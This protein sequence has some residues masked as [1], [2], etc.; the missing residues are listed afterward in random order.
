MEGFQA[1]S[2]SYSPDDH[3]ACR[4]LCMIYGLKTS[5]SR[6]WIGSLEISYLINNLFPGAEC[7]ILHSSKGHDINV[8]PH[9]HPA[10]AC[11]CPAPAV[12]YTHLALEVPPEQTLF[13][14][15]SEHTS[16]LRLHEEHP[17]RD[18]MLKGFRCTQ[19]AES[20]Q[21]FGGVRSTIAFTTLSAGYWRQDNGAPAE[22]GKSYHGWRGWGRCEDCAW[23]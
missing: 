14:S 11:A 13:S 23:H 2:E 10:M 6:R 19:L 17:H 8:P 18:M 1:F 7:R 4:L 3:S 22:C 20:L 5:L 16:H 15:P 21:H 12:E 9:T